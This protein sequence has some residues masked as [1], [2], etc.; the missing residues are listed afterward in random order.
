MACFGLWGPKARDDPLV[1]CADDLSFRYMSARRITVGDVPCWAL[2]VTYVGELGWEL[3]AG[4]EYGARL[5]DTLDRRRPAA[6]AGARRVPGD[7]LAAPGEGLPGLGRG[8]HQRDRSAL[9]RA[10]ASPCAP[11]KA[12]SSAAGRAP[13]RARPSRLCCLV[14]ADPRSVALGNEPVRTPGGARRRAGHQRRPRL[15][16]RRV[17]RLRLAAGR[18]TPRRAPP[19]TVEVFGRAVAAEVRADPL[20]DPTGARIRA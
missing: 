4:S 15:L 9:G 19:L 5:W 1:R 12:A 6:R 18:A 20:Y 17:D 14:L 8:H 16:A 10:R 11:S 13:R 3:Y 7:R 2:R